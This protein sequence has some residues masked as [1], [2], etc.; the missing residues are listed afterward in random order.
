MEA[1]VAERELPP[2]ARMTW[3]SQMTESSPTPQQQ[4][5]WKGR[6]WLAAALIPP[7]AACPPE[8]SVAL[9]PPFKLS[10]LGAPLGPPLAPGAAAAAESDFSHKLSF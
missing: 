3:V 5:R 8:T 6:R 9:L 2:G 7:P 4:N 1:C 10:Q